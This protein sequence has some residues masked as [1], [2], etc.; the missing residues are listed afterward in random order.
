MKVAVT[1]FAHVIV[2]VQVSPFTLSQPLQ[3]VN[4]D[5][6]SASGVR[7][8]VLLAANVWLQLPEQEPPGKKY[9]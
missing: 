9:T 2:T 5:P 4:C 8:T 7:S 1:L 3:P 6:V